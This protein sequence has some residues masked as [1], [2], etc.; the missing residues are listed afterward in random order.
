ML[1]VTGIV[2]LDPMPDNPEGIGA[3]LYAMTTENHITHDELWYKLQHY[4]PSYKI[5][6]YP[7]HGGWIWAWYDDGEEEIW[8]MVSVK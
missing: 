3:H 8:E 5:P 4:W 7:I 1:M 6:P 2:S